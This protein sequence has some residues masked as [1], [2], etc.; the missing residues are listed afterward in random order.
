MAH[1]PVGK[2]TLALLKKLLAKLPQRDPRVVVG[3]KIGEDAAVL[4]LGDR[5]LVVTVDPI[6]FATDE[7]GWYA[8]HVNANDL[9]VRG[10]RPL[11]FTMV[12]L[13]PEGRATESLVEG[14]FA[15]VEEA[16][17]GI[18][19]TV[20]GGHTE[21]TADLGRPILIGGMLG[22]VAKD[23][24]VTTSGARVGDV[25][26]LTK[27]IAVEGTAIM[28]REKEEALK[29]LGCDEDLLERARG[30]LHRPGISVLKEALKG[31]ETVKVHAMHD[32]TEGGLSSG[33]YEL[34]EASGVG[35]RIFRERI[36]I[37]PESLKFCEALDLDP[38]GT[39]ASGALLLTAPPEDAERLLERYRQEGILA[40]AIGEVVG[41]E[42]GITLVAMGEERPFPRFDR[43][44][45]A[46]LF[47]AS[48]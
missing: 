33:L 28:A 25:V 36:P 1:L 6:T 34:A 19:A 23:G 7:I 26:I 17:S 39:I 3:P 15:Q 37:L 30:F 16:C 21:V 20:I 44:E 14:I 47:E 12:L 27:G 38:L 11:W 41:Q 42:K 46:R 8:V 45:I 40:V 43:D 48:S 4:D 24:L 22:E 13:L 32:P 29:R 5:Y 10:A 31:V 35:L 9:A 18:G 2:P